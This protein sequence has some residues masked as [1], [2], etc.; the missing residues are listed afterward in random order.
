MHDIRLV[1]TK[2]NDDIRMELINASFMIGD[3]F[4]DH[5]SVYLNDEL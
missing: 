3:I 4:V 2:N 5:Y 1:W